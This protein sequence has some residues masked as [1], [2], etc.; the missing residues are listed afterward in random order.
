MFWIP[1]VAIHLEVMNLRTSQLVMNLVLQNH[2]HASPNLFQDQLG[3]I[4]AS[5]H[6]LS[7]ERHCLRMV[8]AVQRANITSHIGIRKEQRTTLAAGHS[9]QS[10]APL[11]VS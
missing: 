10:S 9:Q 7:A 11:V 1:F 2:I 6:V 3:V 5:C 8:N 4:L